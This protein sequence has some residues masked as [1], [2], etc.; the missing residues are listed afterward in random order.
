MANSDP[1][2]Y[3][4]GLWILYVLL[5]L[6]PAVVI[7]KLFPDTKVTVSGPLQ[8]LTVNATGAFAAYV[9]TV[10]LGFVPVNNAVTQITVSRDYPYE[11]VIV[12]LGDNQDIDS[13]QFYSRSV[14][15]STNGA[16]QTRD[17]RFVLLLKHPVDKNNPQR[18][19][20]KYWEGNAPS[21]LG[22]PPAST[23]VPMEL[24]ATDSFPQRFRLQIQN[25][26]PKVVPE[27]KK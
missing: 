27:T 21:G 8:N 3:S 2:L 23:I 13:D 18:V 16:H 12:D 5:P 15:A 22:S 20:L 7:F 19:L 17:Y 14:I 9:V 4:F 10:A 6:I 1:V 11:G 25:N 26:Q 24:V